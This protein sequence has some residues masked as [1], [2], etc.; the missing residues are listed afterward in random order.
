MP[1]NATEAGGTPFGKMAEPRP[2]SQPRARYR[3]EGRHRGPCSGN[4]RGPVGDAVG[5]LRR[6]LPVPVPEAGSLEGPSRM[7]REGCDRTDEGAGGRAGEAAREALAEGLA[8]MLAPP[9]V[10]L[11]AVGWAKAKPGRRGC[12]RVG[13]SPCCAGPAWHGREPVVGVRA[14]TV[15]VLADRGG[16][17]A[18]LA[19]GHS[20]GGPCACV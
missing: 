8:G 4:E 10:P 15:G 17:V 16:R 13:G 7:P 14:R 11:D 3:C 2:S 18:R 19:G 6:D 20:G 5:L 1:G 9:G 12:V